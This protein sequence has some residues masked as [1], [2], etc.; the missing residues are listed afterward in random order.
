MMVAGSGQAVDAAARRATATPRTGRRQGPSATREAVLTAAREAF[1]EQGYA[2]TSLR[3]VA[4]RAGVDASLIVHFFGSK[5]GLL[6]AAVQAPF[7]P[8]EMRRFMLAEGPGQA[9]ERLARVFIERWENSG[10]NDA[11][12]TL[13][14]AAISDPRAAALMHEFFMVRLV[15][16]TI[17]HLEADRP[18]LRGSMIA[19][20]LLGFAVARY[21]LRLDGLADCS[22]DEAVAV[23]GASLQRLCT[24][25][26]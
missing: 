7:D 25:P 21:L 6:T 14:Q 2:R 9:G 5:A 22:P 8:D 12:L 26:L 17:E 13:L 24:G 1:G 4:R 15:T 10:E 3:E 18:L 16:P 20:Q 23:L 11:I 19:A